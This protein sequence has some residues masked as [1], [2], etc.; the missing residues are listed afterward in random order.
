MLMPLKTAAAAGGSAA[1]AATTEAPAI[2]AN[3]VLPAVT[4][5][6]QQFT[7][8]LSGELDRSRN[9]TVKSIN[10]RLDST[11]ANLEQHKRDV[12]RQMDTMRSDIAALQRESSSGIIDPR[13]T[14]YKAALVA[15][16]APGRSSSGADLRQYWL[17]RKRLRF[18]PVEGETEPEIWDSLQ[19][20][21]TERMRIPGTD[22]QKS[23]ITEVRRMKSGRGRRPKDEV[24]VAFCD[25]EVRDRVA[26]YAR[27]L[28]SYIGSDGRPTA[29]VRPDVPSHLGGVHRALLQYGYDMRSKYGNE[30]RRNIR[31]EDAD[32][33]FVID[34]MIPG[35]N[36]PNNVW[37]TVDYDHVQEDRKRRAKMARND[38]RL[39][40]TSGADKYNGQNDQT[41]GRGSNGNITASGMGGSS[42]GNGTNAIN[43]GK[44]WG[45]NG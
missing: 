37:T 27:N 31:F 32:H 19:G 28:S 2:A 18:F 12:D 43:N 44:S 16:A 35:P 36:N 4:W 20:F 3:P 34:I 40:S 14:P 39:S 38:E 22:I 9:E 23:K 41:Q 8:Y 42:G 24:I 17:S 1:A 6:W 7:T 29:G 45:S 15:P 13:P 10:T 5:S 30:L 25:V 26:T 21:L 33:T 11:V